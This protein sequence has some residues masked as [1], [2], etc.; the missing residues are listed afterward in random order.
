[1]QFDIINGWTGKS[2]TAV[3]D[4]NYSSGTID[5]GYWLDDNSELG[6]DEICLLEETFASDLRKY[7]REY[8]AEEQWERDSGK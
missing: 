2:R 5:S 4:V 8:A 6:E 1:M 3:V 7:S